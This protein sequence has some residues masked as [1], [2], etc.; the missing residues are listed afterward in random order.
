MNCFCSA[1]LDYISLPGLDL[2]YFGSTCTVDFNVGIIDDDL[3]EL[4]EFFEVFINESSA[5]V[6]SGGV[7]QFLS[8]Q[9]SA[10]ISFLITRAQI[11][12]I[13][14]DSELSFLF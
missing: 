12:I 8:S 5:V 14:T 4:Q 6:S 2:N 7:A 11:F 1:G 3:T 10:R 9:E 13:N